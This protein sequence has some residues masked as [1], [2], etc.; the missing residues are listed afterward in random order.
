MYFLLRINNNLTFTMTEADNPETMQ[1][2]RKKFEAML[3]FRAC[4]AEATECN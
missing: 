4:Y 1:S 2:V 3:A